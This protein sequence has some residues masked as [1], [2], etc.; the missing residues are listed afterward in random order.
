MHVA[1]LL[2]RLEPE[3]DLVQVA[4]SVERCLGALYDAADG[5]R[6]PQAAITE[7]LSEAV[8]AAAG[9]EARRGSL[10]TLGESLERARKLLADAAE[11]LAREPEQPVLAHA[12][13]KASLG[14]PRLH[15]VA[16]VA[17]VPKLRVAAPAP[18]AEAPAYEPLPS[19]KTY[20]ELETFGARAK[21]H[22]AAHLAR[23]LGKGEA[24]SLRAPL[25]KP[26]GERRFV[27]RWAREC[28]EE[29]AMLG[30]QRRPL[31]GDDWRLSSVLEQRMLWALD[32]FAA[33]GAPALCEIEALVLD[34]PAV[35]PP[36]TFAAGLLLGSVDGRDT[37]GMAERIARAASGDPDTLRCFGDALLLAPHPTLD[38]MLR[39][40][41]GD[42]DPAY[43]EVAARVLSRSQPGGEQPRAAAT[44]KDL[45]AMLDDRP[46]I[47]RHAMLPLALAR[48]PVVEGRLR[49]ALDSPHAP[50]R[51]AA[52]RALAVRSRRDAVERLRLELGGAHG[53]EAAA[54]LAAVGSR[55]DA[56]RVCD[57]ALRTP[58]P[59]SLSA[60]GTTGSIGVVSELMEL[61][62]HDDEEV[63]LAAAAALERITGADLR[64][65]VKMA[66]EKLDAPELPEPPTGGFEGASPP[67]RDLGRLA[68]D[69]R[70]APTEGSDDEV[71]LAPPDHAVWRAWWDENRA[72]FE[73]EKRYRRG[74]LF[75]P[76]VA[77]RE[78]DGPMLAFA[79]RRRVAHELTALLGDDAG[80]AADAFVVQQQQALARWRPLAEKRSAVSGGWPG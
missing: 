40:W 34:A 70:F 65:K 9:V 80:F 22:V 66:P 29:I 60:L 16:R 64:R 17:L 55:E 7:A 54:L 5:R 30:S 57:R 78:L 52:W 3:I 48:D 41:L 46:E 67:P 15:S 59:A 71:E 28:F 74:E 4:R 8:A 37:L 45:H 72:R 61:L 50:L 73:P 13:L 39:S 20:E 47:A 49:D 68:S 31:L 36:R 21:A 51:H 19:P 24:R 11:A 1:A 53:D 63:T 18:A 27:A 43:R 58:T 38:G 14:L 23:V 12:E 25:E 33:L 44:P 56:R 62:R 2:E 42:A 76:A 35:D 6:D 69:P 77:W 10:A 26:T 32:A 79:D 75:T